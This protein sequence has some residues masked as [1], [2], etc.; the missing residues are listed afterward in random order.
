M[1]TPRNPDLQEQIDELAAVVAANRTR[2]EELVTR[3]DVSL[4]RADVAERRADDMELRADDS[5]RRVD[6]LEARSAVDR[7]MIAELRADGV[8]ASEHVTQLE[9]ALVTSRV[10]GAAIG[11]LM[12]SRNIGEDEALTLLKGASQRSNTKLRDV[13]ATILAGAD[14]IR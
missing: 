2:L 11:I 14:A 13:A 4:H 1:E 3:A 10:I 6:A 9:T 7:E 8:L 5:E 12:A